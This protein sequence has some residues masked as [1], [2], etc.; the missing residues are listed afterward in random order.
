[1]TQHLADVA[2]YQKGLT[3]AQLRT[4][5]FSIINLKVSH[6]LTRT[7]VA[8]DVTTWAQQVRTAKLGL[9]TFHYL[10]NSATGATQ[11][12]Y[13]FARMKE[14]GPTTDMAHAVDCEDDA[15]ETVYR[16]YV[17][18]MTK[19]LGR[20][21]TTY[22][23]DWWWQARS[24]GWTGT[25]PWLHAAP[26]TGYLNTYPGDT[27]NHWKAGYGGWSQLAVMQY[28]VNPVAGIPVSMSAIKDPATWKAMSTGTTK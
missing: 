6:G 21:I 20:A 3:L 10:N 25:T 1:V 8:A 4:A 13:A 11:A 26:N 12:S 5:G 14:L 24:R 15:T 22:T 23:G 2:A 27:S 18:T 7:S 28:A 9:S 16:D 17:T 19:L